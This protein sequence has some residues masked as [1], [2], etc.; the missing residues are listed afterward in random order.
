MDLFSPLV[1]EERLHPL[2]K[3]IVSETAYKPTMS[4]INQWSDG[5]L[6]R[7]QE[8]NKFI[9][10]FQTTFNSSLWELY[11]NKA[12]IELGYKIDYSKESPDFHLIHSSGGRINVEAVTSNNKN[13]LCTK[14]YSNTSL[15]EAIECSSEDFLDHST[16]KLIGKIKD[17]HEL[18]TGAGGKKRPYS[19]LEHVKGNP[20]VIAIAPFDNHISYAQNNMAI[21]RVLYG[22]DPPTADGSQK[23]IDYIINSN[24]QRIDLGIFTNDTYKNISAVIFSTT[25]TFGKAVVQTSFKG[26]V[27]A[28]RYRQLSIDTF[29]NTEGK[30]SLGRTHIKIDKEHDLYRIRFYDGVHIC[31]ADMHFYSSQKHTESHL[32]GL[33]IYYNPYAE[34]PLSK[35]FFAAR[36]ITQNDYDI[37][38]KRMI[39]N[40]N[41]G[42]LVS[43]QTFTAV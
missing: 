32:D 23:N 14:Y 13:N 35:D 43:R 5:L 11:L 3:K 7:K 19:S 36:E 2:F 24:N 26:M 16:I 41:D 20:F 37:Q 10:E 42:S 33:H 25:G 8:A 40:H 27:K 17:K 28:T 21:N 39:C 4:I 6:G 31:G 15:H 34:I 29:L 1:K 22:V 38:S 9:K 30:N 18:F 12:F